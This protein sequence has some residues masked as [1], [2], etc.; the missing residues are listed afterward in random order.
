[1]KKLIILCV[2]LMLLGVGCGPKSA[3]ERVHMRSGLSGSSL[4]NNIITKPIRGVFEWLT[5]AGIVIDEAVMNRD[6]NSGLLQIFIVG[7]NKSAKTKRFRYRVEWLDANGV[8]IDTRA[9]VWQ[10]MSAMGKS[11]FQIKSVA[12]R[13]EAVNFRMD[14]RKW[15]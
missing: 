10:P 15:E 2:M 12:T 9:S 3:D 8:V 7:R 13:P 4:G 1:M 14:T 5:G 6:N 11:P